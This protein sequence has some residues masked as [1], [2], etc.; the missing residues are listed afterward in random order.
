MVRGSNG[1]IVEFKKHSF[2]SHWFSD[3]AQM[4]ACLVHM[5]RLMKPG[6]IE[7][8]LFDFAQSIFDQATPS[9]SAVVWLYYM[10]LTKL[11][12]D[13]QYLK[14]VEFLKLLF[15]GIRPL[16]SP[17]TVKPLESPDAVDPPL[18]VYGRFE[19]IIM[20]VKD[21]KIG[22]DAMIYIGLEGRS[23]GPEYI[24]SPISGAR[25][26]MLHTRH[27]QYRF[28]CVFSPA[29]R[30][31]GK[32]LKWVEP[33]VANLDDLS[34]E[35][36]ENTLA[37]FKPDTPYE[38]IGEAFHIQYDLCPITT[39][40]YDLD[41]RNEEGVHRVFGF[42]TNPLEFAMDPPN[43][44]LALTAVGVRP[45]NYVPS[46][47]GVAMECSVDMNYLLVDD[48]P[49]SAHNSIQEHADNIF[50]SSL[51]V[52]YKGA[53]V[54]DGGFMIIRSTKTEKAHSEADSE[55]GESF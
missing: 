37:L 26:P 14:S 29:W 4:T 25:A 3:A 10:N 18:V 17:D 9:D 23:K 50:D 19:V 34:K 27:N 38:V 36:F 8:H 47:T 15:S 48:D 35:C 2:V 40:D 54:T 6:L 41:F 42:R 39:D 12:T 53:L 22:Y 28:G 46:A 49:D 55:P 21:T 33:A 45:W 43:F 1:C 31:G 13:I 5:K 7:R 30:R 44:V 16:G 51:K 20:P 32:S 11:F 24:V 52:C